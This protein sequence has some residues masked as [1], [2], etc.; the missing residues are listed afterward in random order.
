MP[1]KSQA[2]ELGEAHTAL[3]AALRATGAHATIPQLKKMAPAIEPVLKQ[4]WR[5][6]SPD[7][8]FVSLYL[9]RAARNIK[10]W[11]DRQ[12]PGQ[13]PGMDGAS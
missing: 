6:T 5:G 9:E 11:D 8:R 7:Y 2:D 4:R 12:T 1:R 13:L 3:A 10:L